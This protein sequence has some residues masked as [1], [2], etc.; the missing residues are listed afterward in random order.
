[1]SLCWLWLWLWI[2]GVYGDIGFFLMRSIIKL[3]LIQCGMKYGV[4]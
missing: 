2:E 4:E 1:M 3:V